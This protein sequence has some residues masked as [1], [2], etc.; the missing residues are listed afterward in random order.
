MMAE[1]GGEG[2][3]K[4]SWLEGC[5]L[6]N[7]VEIRNENTSTAIS[8]LHVNRRLV[9]GSEAERPAKLTP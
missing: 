7:G 6:H 8:G 1:G 2:G 9:R 5:G 3:D 4:E